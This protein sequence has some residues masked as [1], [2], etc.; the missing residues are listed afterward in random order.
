MLTVIIICFILIYLLVIGLLVYGFDKVEEFKI[1][2]LPAKTKFSVIIPF[3]NEAGNLPKLLNAMAKLN[4]PKSLFE[5]ILVNDDSND[6]SVAVIENTLNSI[7]LKKRFTR[8]KNIKIIDNQRISDSPKKDAI[9]SAIKVSKY[10]WIVTTDAD[11]ISPKYWLD[12]FDEQIQISSTNCIVA[13]VT[14]HGKT[15]FFNRFQTLDFLSLQG[16]TIGSFGIK[17]PILCNGA[18]FA[19]LKSEFNA[20][21]GFKGNDTIAS[22]DDVFLLDKFLKKDASKVRYLKSKQVIVTTNPAE[23]FK[24]LI[25]QRIRWASKTSQLN[26]WFTKFIGLVVILGNFVCVAF[27]PAIILNLIAV[28]IAI[29]LFIIKFCIDFLLLFKASRFFKQ[30]TYLLSFIISSFLYPAFNIGVF[31]L[32]FFKSY[33]WKGRTSKK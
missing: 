5:V 8:N 15:S 20:L 3:R 6:D 9:T 10:N 11:C 7:A 17:K 30:E 4:Y 31:I 26:N 28:K 16:A 13:P 27:I 33:R 21:D 22:G 1:Q 12:C 29:A 25:H 19:Y 18:N 24:S 32:S 14:Y 2:D 23:N